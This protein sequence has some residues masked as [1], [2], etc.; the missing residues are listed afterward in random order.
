MGFINEGLPDDSGFSSRMSEDSASLRK[1]PVKM[2]ELKKAVV[3]ADLDD[4]DNG[5]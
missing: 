2:S 5:A 3:V 4:K 1:V